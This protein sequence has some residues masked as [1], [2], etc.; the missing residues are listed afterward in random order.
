MTPTLR[1]FLLFFAA[2][3]ALLAAVLYWPALEPLAGVAGASLYLPLLALSLLG[4]P[5][6]AGAKPGGWASPGPAGY[7]AAALVW[8]ALWLLLAYALARLLRK[9]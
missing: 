1:L 9:D 6:F 5:L 8:A 4:V 7:A 3:A 2:H